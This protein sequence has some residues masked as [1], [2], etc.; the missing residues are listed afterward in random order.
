MKHV[1]TGGPG[2][3]KS[4]VLEKLAEEHHT[5]D[6]VARDI[7]KSGLRPEDDLI[8]FQKAVAQ[9]QKRREQQTKTPKFLDRSLVD[10][11]AYLEV[12][13]GEPWDELYQDI[14]QAN[15]ERIFYMEKLPEDLYKKD[16]VRR[17]SPE[18]QQKIH[19]KIY[20]VYDRFGYDIVKVPLFEIGESGIEKRAEFIKRES[21]KR[22]EKEIEG[23]YKLEGNL[24]D[25]LKGY[26]TEWKTTKNYENKV[27]A[28]NDGHILRLRIDKARDWK[29]R[30]PN[31]ILTMKGPNQGEEFFEREEIETQLSIEPRKVLKSMPAI[32]EYQ[33]KRV[34]YTP[35]GDPNCKLCEDR[36]EDLGKF[37]EIEAQTKNQVKLW[38]ERLGIEQDSITESYAE[39]SLPNA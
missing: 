39:M 21:K 15:Y 7:M 26:K 4:S 18:L 24:R 32:S 6:E 13:N 14:E 3:G 1:I 8:G 30:L 5:I 36:V 2:T 31:Y 38:K 29:V 35:V 12:F 27:L 19:D 28:I 22:G 20:E 16:E 34:I 25:R 37:V 23:K 33:T 10:I 11:I 17:E 9:E